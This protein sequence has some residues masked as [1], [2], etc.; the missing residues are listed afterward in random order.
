[1]WTHTGLSGGLKK[2]NGVRYYG[3]SKTRPWRCLAPLIGFWL[4]ASGRF[5]AF[6]LLPT[7]CCYSMRPPDRTQ[8]VW[9]KCFGFG[10][11]IAGRLTN[12]RAPAFPIGVPTPPLLAVL[13][14]C[15]NSRTARTL[16]RV[17]V[18]CSPAS[19]S[20]YRW[21]NPLGNHR[22]CGRPPMRRV[23]VLCSAPSSSHCRG[24]NRGFSRL[25]WSAEPTLLSLSWFDV[26][27]GPSKG[28]PCV[29]I[30]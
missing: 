8:P 27:L 26:L 7:R 12:I 19:S 14:G 24:A 2:S 4:W 10:Y 11:E 5:W 21:L 15:R 28:S 23:S 1:M 16:R 30:R 17:S 13:T 29:V 6:G 22:E 25:D 20:R 18:L 9:A 3:C